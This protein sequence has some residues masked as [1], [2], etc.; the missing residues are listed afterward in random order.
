MMLDIIPQLSPFV[1]IVDTSAVRQ[2]GRR[3]EM[4]YAAAFLRRFSS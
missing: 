2:A 1:H 3:W 4:R